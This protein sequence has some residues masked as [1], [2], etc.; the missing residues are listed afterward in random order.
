MKRFSCPVCA[1]RVHFRNTMCLNCGT[2]LAYLPQAGAMAPLEGQAPCANRGLIACNWAAGAGRFCDSCAM[3]EV[4]PDLDV[5]GNLR[6]WTQLEL[7]KRRLCYSLIALGLPFVSARGTRLRFRFLADGNGQTVMTG[8][9]N[10]IITLN[11]AE[12]DDDEREAR[13]VAMGEP[14][15]TL[16]GHL[17][18]EVGH[19][20]WQI[21]VAEA[22]RM[23]EFADLFGDASQDYQLALARHYAQGPPAGWENSFVSSYATSHPW[24]DWAE[25]WAHMLHIIDGLDTARHNGL[26][27]PCAEIDAHAVTDPAILMRAWIPLSTAMNEMTRSIGQA[28]FYPFAIAPPVARKIGFMLRIIH[29]APAGGG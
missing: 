17:R 6:R 15:R 21:L 10:G 8:H 16:L 29:A 26:A 9:D 22:G 27:L 7:A 19:Y 4:I 24:E 2:A 23:G 28:D 18:H 11:I 12:A 13:R 3:T 5:P 20:Y 1:H 14:Y 25:T